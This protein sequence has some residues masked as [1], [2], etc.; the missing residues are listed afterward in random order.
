MYSQRGRKLCRLTRDFVIDKKQCTV[1]ICGIISLHA[2]PL[3]SAITYKPYCQKVKYLLMNLPL[4][5]N[6]SFL[7]QK[8]FMAWNKNEI[9]SL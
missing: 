6:V 5:D 9:S 3:K 4:R 2:E 7:S 1:I 8:L